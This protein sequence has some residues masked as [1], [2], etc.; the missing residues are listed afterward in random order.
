M[1]AWRGRLFAMVV[2]P[3]RFEFRRLIVIDS[4]ITFLSR[5]NAFFFFFWTWKMNA[6]SLDFLPYFRVRR[7]LWRSWTGST[8]GSQ[9]RIPIETSK[10]MYGFHHRLQ[11]SS[12]VS[13]SMLVVTKWK[14][15]FSYRNDISRSDST[16]R[17]LG[18]QNALTKKLYDYLFIIEMRICHIN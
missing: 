8:Q 13:S 10:F 6:I 16:E 14:A 3:C 12:C 9:A 18:K 4:E 15:A 11:S 1:I 2:F 5:W 7:F 17:N